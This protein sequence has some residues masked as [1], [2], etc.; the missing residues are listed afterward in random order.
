MYIFVCNI[1]RFDNDILNFHQFLSKHR[2]LRS[3]EY[4]WIRRK[5]NRLIF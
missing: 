2:S 1:T 5:L 3:G 4:S